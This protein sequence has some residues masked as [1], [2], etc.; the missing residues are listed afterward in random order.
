MDWQ[1][2]SIVKLWHVHERKE[3]DN[4]L[5]V[6]D[7]LSYQHLP[8]HLLFAIEYCCCYQLLL[9]PVQININNPKQTDQTHNILGR[10]IDQL[11]IVFI[12]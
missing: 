2:S 4:N 12:R 5:T 9:T 6:F 8:Y 11:M 10:K 3:K 7:I 1:V